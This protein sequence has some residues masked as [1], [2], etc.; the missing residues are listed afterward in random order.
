M[1]LRNCEDYGWLVLNP[2]VEHS[3]VAVDSP[4]SLVPSGVLPKVFL[5]F[6]TSFSAG[7]TVVPVL[8]LESIFSS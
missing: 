1:G 3:M 7:E 4:D 2:V 6:S 5:S 8:V